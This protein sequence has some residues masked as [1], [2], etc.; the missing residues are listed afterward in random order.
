M[1]W[2]LGGEKG[3]VPA[4][5]EEFDTLSWNKRGRGHEGGSGASRLSS[6]F[7]LPTPGLLS[8]RPTMLAR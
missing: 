5:R 8:R 6:V 4:T 2:G 3:N 7:R 1:P